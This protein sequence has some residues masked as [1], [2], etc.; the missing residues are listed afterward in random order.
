M[1]SKLIEIT[2]ILIFRDLQSGPL[3]NRKNETQKAL[4]YCLKVLSYLR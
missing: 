2:L 3:I 4:K 1:L